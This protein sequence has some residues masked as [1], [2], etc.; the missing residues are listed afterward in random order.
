M[1][2][3][4][5]HF[6]ASGRRS[7]EPPERGCGSVTDDGV[8]AARQDRRQ[9]VRSR[10][11]KRVPNKKDTPTDT[12]KRTTSHL[13]SDPA[14]AE[15]DDPKLIGCY[16]AKLTFRDPSEGVVTSTRGGDNVTQRMSAEDLGHKRPLG[17]GFRPRSTRGRKR[18]RFRAV[19]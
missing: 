14:L 13:A 18:G 8:P 19:R 4:H 9:L 15:A 5:A 3:R 11:R 10:H 6:D 16:E 17:G 1:A 12:M 7:R 2:P